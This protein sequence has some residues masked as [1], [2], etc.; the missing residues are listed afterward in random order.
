M[1][2]A[3]LRHVTD[4]FPSGFVVKKRKTAAQKAEEAAR[5]A[6]EERI[7]KEQEEEAA[8]IEAEKKKKK[9]TKY[10]AEGGSTWEFLV[11]WVP[12]DVYRPTIPRLFD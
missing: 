6:E 2:T 10:P 12:T 8:R 11:V 4:S 9:P 1:N 3:L 5:K 7:K